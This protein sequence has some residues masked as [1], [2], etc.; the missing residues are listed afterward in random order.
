[1][2]V[3]KRAEAALPQGE[4]ASGVTENLG[5]T[6]E[7]RMRKVPSLPSGKTVSQFGKAFNHMFRSIRIHESP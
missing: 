2:S 7:P 1:M 4:A 3:V 6:T 5:P